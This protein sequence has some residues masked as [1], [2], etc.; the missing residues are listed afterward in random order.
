MG[1]SVGF[2]RELQQQREARGVALEAIASTTKVSMQHLRALE[3]EKRSDLPGGVFNKGIVRNYCRVVGLE[4]G[5]WLERFAASDLG[6]AAEPDWESFAES[7][8]RNRMAA[9]Q[10]SRRG[11]LGVLLMLVGL[12]AL[13]W[14]AWHFAVRPRLGVQTKAPGTAMRAD[15][16]TTHADDETVVMNGA[17][18]GRKPGKLSRSSAKQ[19]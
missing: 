15:S 16:G 4:E 10:H 19:R 6:E 17:P 13:A 5:E 9:R 12:G 2:G 18:G 8:K 1:V 3:A 7:V 11:W 14:T